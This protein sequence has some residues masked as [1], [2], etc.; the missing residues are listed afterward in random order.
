MLQGKSTENV[1]TC[2][3]RGTGDPKRKEGD[4]R[5]SLRANSSAERGDAQQKGVN[6]KGIVADLDQEPA[7]VMT[8]RIKRK[9]KLV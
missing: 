5:H 7:L 2:L 4:T 3:L 6:R 8:P 9:E 1:R